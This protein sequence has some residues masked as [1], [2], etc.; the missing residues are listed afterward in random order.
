MRQSY[1]GASPGSS[2]RRESS[3]GGSA[4]SSRS[5]APSSEP[6]P[7]SS[8]E[9]IY[10]D[11]AEI[12]LGLSPANSRRLLS[13]FNSPCHMRRRVS[14]EVA[15]GQLSEAALERH[16]R[17]FESRERTG[18]SPHPSYRFD[19][20]EERKSMTPSPS[21][22]RRRT[23]PPLGLSLSANAGVFNSP[24]AA[25]RPVHL[26]LTV[27]SPTQVAP[28]GGTPLGGTTQTLYRVRSFSTSS[29]G[30][31]NRGDCLRVRT[32][33]NNL[34]SE[35]KTSTSSSGS[36]LPEVA[37]SRTSKMDLKS[38]GTFHCVCAKLSAPPVYKVLVLGASNVG[39]TSLTQQFMTSEYMGQEDTCLS[40][41]RP[42]I[43]YECLFII[44]CVYF[45]R[46]M[47]GWFKYRQRTF[48]HTNYRPIL[49]SYFFLIV[50]TFLH[51][52]TCI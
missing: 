1:G 26:H 15:V 34:S 17:M 21:R 42:A 23:H 48:Q 41:Y 46:F 27:A 37:P 29:K 30:L 35:K 24:P 40:K 9:S 28:P 12:L 47:S 49:K 20:S 38:G 45:S 19:L 25:R 50:L 18:R 11:D 44:H 13:P 3:T 43:L 36:D 2:G 7:P 51:A 39:K 10:P 5:P 32:T 14:P 22:R 16:T 6:S 4:C 8:P 33:S 31:I 52:L